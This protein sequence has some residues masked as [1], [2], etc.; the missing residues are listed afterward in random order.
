[1]EVIRVSRIGLPQVLLCFVAL[2][3]VVL[4]WVAG[5][6]IPLLPDESVLRTVDA[7]NYLAA[8]QSF[9]QGNGLIDASSR[10][11]TLFPPG[12][13]VVI[14]ALLSAGMSAQVAVLVV[15]GSSL[16][17][18]ILATYFL[19]RRIFGNEWLA[20]F[21]AALVGWNPSVLR[22]SQQLWTEPLF[23]ALGMG[24]FLLLVRS[25]QTGH[26]SRKAF[27]VASLLVWGA[28]W[29]K[30]LGVSFAFVLACAVFLLDANSSM[31]DRWIRTVLALGAGL[32]GLVPLAIRNLLLG[33]GA[34]GERRDPYVSIE[35][36]LSNGLQEFGRILVQPET[37]GL[38]GILGVMLG[39]ALIGGL[40]IAWY[41]GNEAVQLVG[42]G[43]VL[44]WAFFWISQVRTHVDAD[45]ERFIIPMMG[46]MVIL[47]LYA[48]L[49]VW[50]ITDETLVR[51]GHQVLAR[52]GLIA[53]V[54]LG[55]FILVAN[56]A[57]SYLIAFEG[58]SA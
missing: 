24:L 1:M 11:L 51:R 12:L 7:Q 55:I 31:R 44:Y 36:A 49:E 26:L 35:G 40:W 30:Y 20:L 18:I 45:I 56:A 21:A 23:A 22:T 43:V 5:I 38:S 9:S 39:V 2:S 34:F 15:N 32:V 6:E 13:P 19:A 53:C 4:L 42:F 10:P 3:S 46:P 50:R 14:G 27:V 47:A 17:L 28:I 29:L 54:L 37:S 41:R 16:L 33:S 8:A 58:M 48:L 52:T 25:I 57:K